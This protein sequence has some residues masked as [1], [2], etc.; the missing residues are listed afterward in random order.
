[1]AAHVSENNTRMTFTISK[2]LKQKAEE[3]ATKERRSLSNFITVVL[4]QYLNQNI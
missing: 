3:Q 4:E 2:E 1:M